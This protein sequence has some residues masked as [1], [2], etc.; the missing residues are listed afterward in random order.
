MAAEF[1]TV[2]KTS[3]IAPGAVVSADVRGT[4]IAV[5]NVGG[6]YYAFDD[7]CTH[8]QCSLAERGELA[9]TTVTCTCH[10]PS[11]TC[12]R[13]RC[14]RLR[15]TAVRVYPRESPAMRCRSRSDGQGVRRRR[16]KPGG[17]HRRRDAPRRG[18][19]WQRDVDRRRADC[20]TNDPHSPKRTCAARHRSTSL[21]CGRLRITPSTASR[22][23]WETSR[24]HRHP[25]RRR[26][27]GSAAGAV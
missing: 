11:S 24:A 8:E 4:R 14:S 1:L 3:Q 27:R 19:G 9:G 12:G 2:F 17:R 5:A 13:G 21:T 20:R 16:R 7:T 6:T 26:A 25:A 23:C 15:R 22:R 10:G 18:G